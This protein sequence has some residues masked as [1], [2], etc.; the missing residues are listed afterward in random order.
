MSSLEGSF[1]FGVDLDG[2]V[3]DFYRGLKPIAAEWVG[4]PVEE[5]PDAFSF[6]LEEWGFR[7][8]VEY[9]RLHRFAIAERSLYENLSPIEGAGPALRRL[10]SSGVRIRIITHRLYLKHT[11]KTSV[12]Q[13]VGWLD[14]YAIPYWDLCFMSDKGAVGADLYV[15]DAPSNIEDL[16]AGGNEAIVFTA[17]TNLRVGPPRA[18]DWTELERMV[19]EHMERQGR[20]A[21]A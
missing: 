3:A 21:T 18:N 10:S 5:L 14:R 16:R 20:C 4:R 9:E 13:T 1:V 17:P 8:A 15:D 11:H 19:V 6:G 12:A 2:V 7:S